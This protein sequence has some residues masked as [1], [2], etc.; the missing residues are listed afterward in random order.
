VSSEKQITLSRAELYERVWTAP[1]R[2]V[3]K[4]LGVSD[5]GLAKIC[6]RHEIPRPE[7]GHWVR[8]SLGQNPERADL[9]ESSD[10]KL[11]V[12]Q[13]TIRPKAAETLTHNIEPEVQALLVPGAIAVESDRPISHPLVLRTKKSLAHPRKDERGFLFPKEGKPLPHIRVSQGSL[14]RALS[15]L[16][17]LFR[18]LADQK[19]AITWETSEEAKLHVTV[20][21][22]RVAFWMGERI[23]RVARALTPQEEAKKKASPYSYFQQWDYKPTGELSLVISDVP[24]DSRIRQTWA[25]GTIQ[26]LEKCLGDFVAGL[27]L[28][29]LAIKKKRAEREQWEREWNERQR[30]RELEQRREAE[31]ER[32]AKIISEATDAWHRSERIAEFAVALG[33]MH[34]RNQLS[35]GESRDLGRLARWAKGYARRLNPILRF[36]NLVAEFK[37]EEDDD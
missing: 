25:D 9:P 20:L 18:A 31:F 28:T 2:T 35:D 12:I 34:E 10:A 33:T 15:I 6:E 30:R 11:D 37:G 5:V 1:L 23:Q 19:I 8:V 32:K 7:Q 29:A 16:D 3:A 36:E 24:Y 13:I 14:P 17:A 21:G 22:E 26:R 27:Y 4:E